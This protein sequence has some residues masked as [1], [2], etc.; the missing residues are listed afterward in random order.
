MLPSRFPLRVLPQVDGD[1]VAPRRA[2][3]AAALVDV[4]LQQCLESRDDVGMFGGEIRCLRGVAR[5]IVELVRGRFCLAASGS[6]GALQPP[7]PGQRA[8]FQFPS[9]MAKLPLMEWWMIASRGGVRLA[10]RAGSAGRKLMLS[11]PASSGSLTPTHFGAGGHQVA[12]AEE[13]I[14]HVG[15]ASPPRASGR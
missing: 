4:A 12:E 3:R 8:S 7:E 13:A 15:R 14:V 2:G 5:E 9:R 1:V 6:R 10:V 11:S